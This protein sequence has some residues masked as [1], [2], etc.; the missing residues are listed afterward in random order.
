MFDSIRSRILAAST[1]IVICSLSINT[2]LNYSIANKYNN[3]DRQYP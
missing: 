1:A 2:Y 3:S